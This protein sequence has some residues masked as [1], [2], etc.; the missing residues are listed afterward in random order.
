MG[1]FQVFKIV[2]MVPNRATH[3]MFVRKICSKLVLVFYINRSNMLEIIE[4]SE[5][6]HDVFVVSNHLPNYG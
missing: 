2:Q 6:E 5:V 3:H 1:V 4:K